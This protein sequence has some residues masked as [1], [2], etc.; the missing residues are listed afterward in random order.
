M[1]FVF[2]KSSTRSFTILINIPRWFRL[3]NIVKMF[4]TFHTIEHEDLDISWLNKLP[5]PRLKILVK[6][7]VIWNWNVMR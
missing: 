7:M 6:L 1:S 3:K 5:P 4:R 2:H